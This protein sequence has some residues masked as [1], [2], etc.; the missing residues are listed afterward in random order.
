MGYRLFSRKD[1]HGLRR[2]A[3]YIWYALAYLVGAS[4]D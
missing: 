3:R 4:H 2:M 1:T